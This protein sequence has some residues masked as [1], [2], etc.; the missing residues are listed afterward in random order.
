MPISG[1]LSGGS[2]PVIG[3]GQ[4]GCQ[5]AAAF[6]LQLCEDHRI[7]PH[8]GKSVEGATGRW[9]KLFTRVRGEEAMNVSCLA[10]FSS[11]PTRGRG[12]T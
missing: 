2:L 6:W 1:D 8:S 5:M 10:R 3:I 4:A 7:D 12:T 9:E 11:T